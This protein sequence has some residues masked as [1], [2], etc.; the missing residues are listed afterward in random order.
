[1][2]GQI[3]LDIFQGTCGDSQV[4]FIGFFQVYVCLFHRF[5]IHI[6]MAISQV[7]DRCTL[8]FFVVRVQKCI[9]AF[10]IVQ[11]T[12]GDSQVSFDRYT[13]IYLLQVQIYIYISFTGLLYIYICLFYRSV[14]Y[15]PNL[16]C[17]SRIDMYC[18]L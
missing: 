14:I 4:S 5:L 16:F 2:S 17:L 15:I 7:F 13:Y 9:G 1:M 3:C 10:G 6:Y 11:S 8:F 12:C 18:R